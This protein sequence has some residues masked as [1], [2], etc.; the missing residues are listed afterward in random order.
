MYIIKCIV[1]IAKRTAF[2]PLHFFL[3][4]FFFLFSFF[5]LFWILKYSPSRGYNRMSRCSCYMNLMFS[6]HECGVFSV[7]NV[8]IQSKDMR[9]IENI[10]CIIFSTIGILGILFELVVVNENFH[11][12]ES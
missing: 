12:S 5:L 10:K 3:T 2:C 7:Q 11:F 6:Y 8:R 1:C 9:E 4:I